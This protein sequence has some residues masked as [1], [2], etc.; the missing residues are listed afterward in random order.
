MYCY[1]DK[2]GG[3]V[4]QHRNRPTAE[5]KA[6]KKGGFVINDND[7]L[8]TLEGA[9]IIITTIP[10]TYVSVKSSGCLSNSAY[11]RCGTGTSWKCF[12]RV[13]Q[14]ALKTTEDDIY[15]EENIIEVYIK[16]PSVRADEIFDKQIKIPA[17]VQMFY[18]SAGRRNTF[19]STYTRSSNAPDYQEHEFRVE[20]L[21]KDFV[22][23]EWKTVWNGSDILID[24]KKLIDTQAEKRMPKIQFTKTIGENTI[25]VGGNESRSYIH[26]NGRFPTNMSDLLSYG[27]GKEPD[28]YFTE[29]F[30]TP[31]LKP[32]FDWACAILVSDSFMDAHSKLIKEYRES[33]AIEGEEFLAFSWGG[34]HGSGLGTARWTSGLYFFPYKEK[35][36]ISTTL[37]YRFMEMSEEWGCKRFDT[38]SHH[39]YALQRSQ[40]DQMLVI[41]ETEQKKKEKEAKF[42]EI[43]DLER[44]LRNYSTSYA[45]PEEA[46]IARGIYNNC[47]N[48][49]GDGYIPQ[50]YYQDAQTFKLLKEELDKLKAEIEQYD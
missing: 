1:Y 44:E 35:V 2:K 13:Q 41:A 11:H 22:V 46:T 40:Y 18:L 9:E 26:L 39:G 45:T 25:E 34:D 7:Y 32:L 17:G 43:A 30:L 50:S 31:D 29:K 33:I 27:K 15:D 28:K 8:V 6:Q 24:F 49:G 42:K 10:G 47:I 3:F 20:E 37:A 21:E 36:K 16:I 14:G 4:S 19:S 48:E 38:H 5:I 23:P 12:Y